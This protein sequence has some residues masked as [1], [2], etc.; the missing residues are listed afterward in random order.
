MG[1]LL[2]GT[3]LLASFLGGV[4]A[5]LAPCCVSVMLP[6]Y[7]STGFRHRGGVLPATLVFGAGVATV[8]LPIGLGATALS[9]LL[10]EQHVWLFSAGG[11]L[12]ILAGAAVLAGWKPNLPMPGARRVK[13]GSFGSAYALGTF[14]GLASACCAP[15]LV[16]VAVLSGA[17][18]S[19]PAALAIGLSYVAGMVA[20]LALVA[21]LWDRRRERASTVLSDRPVRLRLGRWQRHLALGT[22]VSGL[23]MIGM[24]VLAL[25]L[26]FTGPGMPSG[27][28]QTELSA[29]LQHLSSVTVDALSWIPGWALALILA[30]GFALL[31]RR[32][33]REKT[34]R[35][36]NPAPCCAG[37]E[38]PEPTSIPATVEENH[39]EQD[40]R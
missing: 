17:S 3:T 27:G 15:V 36:A 22:L 32:A 25:V 9:R 21:V 18:A 31:L 30:A 38:N 5:L 23:L 6:A 16:G 37:E 33:T 24:G 14:S 35:P 39:R 26:A 28:W 40:Q 29:W 2:F 1:E 34:S 10:V 8:I 12:M 20:P 7:L 11:A 4:V 13:E 19:F